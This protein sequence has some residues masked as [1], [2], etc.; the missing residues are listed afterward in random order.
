MKVFISHQR[1]DAAVATQISYRLT[2]HNIESY[3]DVID[4]DTSKSGDALGEYVREQLGKCTQLMAVVSA[5]TKSS[6]WVPWEIGLATEKDFP[7][8]T[9]ACDATTL[10]EYLRKWPYLRTYADIE[11]YVKSARGADS[12]RIIR[13]SYQS[14]AAARRSATAEFHAD[15]KK[16]L[17]Q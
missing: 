2:L 9:Y 13:K 15:L 3:L 8:S 12:T 7:I 4:P 16:R 17:H 5:A 14:E 6:W 1:I 11:E 10:P